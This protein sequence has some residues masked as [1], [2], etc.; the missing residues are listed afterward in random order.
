MFSTDCMSSITA[1]FS[2]SSVQF[3]NYPWLTVCMSDFQISCQAR[4]LSERPKGLDGIT[5][6]PTYRSSRLLNDI[7][8]G[9]SLGDEIARL[10]AQRS[11][12]RC[13]E[14]IAE[15]LH[16]PE[17]DC[18]CL[19][20]DA[21]LAPDS[22]IFLALRD[23]I[24]E[25]DWH[26]GNTKFARCNYLMVLLL[27]IVDNL[28]QNT[29]N[30]LAEVTRTPSV[31]ATCACIIEAIHDLDVDIEMV[32][33]DW[34]A[35]FLIRKAAI[36]QAEA[37]EVSLREAAC[38]SCEHGYQSSTTVLTLTQLPRACHSAMSL[39]RLTEIVRHTDVRRGRRG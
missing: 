9:Q 17:R 36:G 35:H 22:T 23:A 31:R 26:C 1:G 3:P 20:E 29:P 32:V 10:I 7:F 15:I 33:G 19:R 12:A 11:I 18:K 14:A 24:P 34:S 39:S 4:Q 2:G 27:E 21:E 38:K 5:T 16:E 13:L 6:H 30:L 8:V 37:E 25:Y 28:G